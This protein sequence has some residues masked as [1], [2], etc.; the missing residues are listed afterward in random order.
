M[1]PKG[2]GSHE[3]RRPQ[4]GR[5]SAEPARLHPL[6]PGEDAGT[7]HLPRA[8]DQDR[9]RERAAL[10]RPLVRTAVRAARGKAPMSD[11][12]LG[13]TGQVLSPTHLWER[14]AEHDPEGEKYLEKRGLS[15]AVELGLVRFDAGSGYRVV[16]PIRG[17]K[18]PD[19][20]LTLQSRNILPTIPKNDRQ[21]SLPGVKYPDG[22][23][24]GKVKEARTAKRVYLCEG[25]A[26]TLALQIAGTVAIGAPGAGTLQHLSKF[27]GSKTTLRKREAVLCVQ[28][29]RESEEAFAKLAAE[30][31]RRGASVSYLRTSEEHGKDAADWLKAVGEQDFARAAEHNLSLPPEP[32]ELEPERALA[33]E[34]ATS[35]EGRPELEDACEKIETAP[36]GQG[37]STFDKQC[38]R[39][40]GLVAGGEIE[41][42]EA[43][44]RLKASGHKRGLPSREINSRFRRSFAAGREHPRKLAIRKLAAEYVFVKEQGRYFNTTTGGICRPEALDTNYRREVRASGVRKMRF[45]DL[46]NPHMGRA[47]D[48]GFYPGKGEIFE[49]KGKVLVNTWREPPLPPEKG[50]PPTPWLQLL[51][52]LLPDKA[53]EVR[54][55]LKPGRRRRALLRRKWRLAPGVDQHLPLPLED[56]SLAGVEPEVVRPA[57]VR[58]DEIG[59]AHLAYP[60]RAH[61]AAIVGVQRLGP[62]DAAGGGV[63]VAALLLDEDVLRGELTD[64]KFPRMF[65]PGREGSPEPAVDFPAGKTA[66]VPGRLEAR[67]RFFFLD[68]SSRHQPAD[69]EA[70]LVESRAALTLRRRLDLLASILQ[71]GPSLLRGGA[72]LG[73]GSL[74]FQLGRL[75][76][77][78]EVVLGRA[79]EVLLAHRLEPVGGVLAVLLRGAQVGDAR[80][81]APQLGGELGERLFAL[82]IILDAE[83]RLALAERRLAAE[84]LGE[85]LERPSPRRPDGDGHG[86]LQ[87]QGVREPFAQIDALR[88]ARLLDLPHRSAVRVLD[89]GQRTLPVVLRDGGEDVARL[90]GQDR[91]GV[92]GAAHRDH[93]PIA[94]AGVEPHQPQLDGAG[95]AALLQILL[96]LWVM[97]RHPL[98]QV[99]RGEHLAGETERGVAHRSL[100]SCRSDGSA[101]QGA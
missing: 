85:M 18:D 34:S 19:A 10:S 93:H 17:P 22:A 38:F 100:S 27:L 60:R 25:L 81:P 91:V 98:P 90:Q 69:A 73:Q 8:A 39:I 37:G 47:D 65:P 31:R 32:A 54:Q 66:L 12:A 88:R 9:Q 94:A 86:A 33:Q 23:A 4:E 20:I 57:H 64:G 82:S 13:F 83:D 45:T 61:F 80:A 76:R 46:I 36:K 6:P 52:Y 77:E 28:N 63:E 56:F 68:L 26:D 16:V 101:H 30:L 79:G 5:G 99:R 2:G 41:E 78:G 67:L 96:P 97:L 44:T 58:I 62:A 89:A 7:V 49:W 51:A 1:S 84:E 43:E 72:L 95:E 29:D 70:L 42:E 24:M 48:F 15:R 14:M 75:G 74:R 11:A 71:L 3:H 21:R 35:E 59:E 87:R 92:L 40:G 55:E 50:P 53:E